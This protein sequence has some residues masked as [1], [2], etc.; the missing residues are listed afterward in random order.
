M[1]ILA[2][3]MTGCRKR[4]RESSD[5]LRTLQAAPGIRSVTGMGLML[6]L[7]SIS[8]PANLRSAL[9]VAY[10]HDRLAE[11]P[12]SPALNIPMELLK[13]AA[14]APALRG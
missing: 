11:D 6:G 4:V 2:A 1:N 13:T 8:P 9:R 7:R 12:S 3:S 14:Q 10:C 5:Y